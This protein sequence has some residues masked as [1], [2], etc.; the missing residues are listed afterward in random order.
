MPRLK[1]K[2]IIE[3][4]FLINSKGQSNVIKDW[5]ITWIIYHSLVYMPDYKSLF[6]G[7]TYGCGHNV[8]QIEDLTGVIISY[9][10]Y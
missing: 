3:S 8:S 2:R 10:T 5:A 6:I 4:L 9:E 7:Q 1:F